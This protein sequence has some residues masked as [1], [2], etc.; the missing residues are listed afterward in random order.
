MGRT[1]PS[2]RMVLEHERDLWIKYYAK[3]LRTPH[4]AS[5][6]KLWEKAFQLADAAS[7]N[8]R[9]VALDN[10]LMSMLVAQQSEIQLLRKAI[11]TMQQQMNEQ[12]RSKV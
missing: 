10:I 6:D 11:A 7:A 5:F 9:P 12:L 1:L 8:T 3:R 4:R 2:Y